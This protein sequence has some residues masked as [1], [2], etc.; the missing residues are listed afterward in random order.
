MPNIKRERLRVKR[1][2]LEFWRAYEPFV[3]PTLE[4][5]ENAPEPK[6]V[7]KHWKKKVHGI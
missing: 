1:A 6:A 5:L 3:G 7:N 2:H 4:Q